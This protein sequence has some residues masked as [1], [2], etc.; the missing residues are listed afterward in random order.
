MM[1]IAIPAILAFVFLLAARQVK[2]YD[3]LTMI[4]KFWGILT[5]AG[6]F[7]ALMISFV[8]SLSLRRQLSVQSTLP[9]DEDSYEPVTKKLLLGKEWLVYNGKETRIYSRSDIRT[10]AIEGRRK[11]AAVR[12]L[13]SRGT[14]GFT[15]RGDKQE[16]ETKL[17]QWLTQTEC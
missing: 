3:A 13:C 6:V 11:R 5:I 9:F 12:I 16:I 4:M 15:L 8:K 7:A 1:A 2:A 14:E 17:T 10:L